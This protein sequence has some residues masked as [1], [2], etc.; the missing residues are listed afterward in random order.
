MRPIIKIIF[1]VV[2][3]LCAMQSVQAG[4]Q[5]EPQ[6]EVKGVSGAVLQNVT[7]RLTLEWRDVNI[8][9]AGSVAQFAQ[10]SQQA[11]KAA[12]A[13]YGYYQPQIQVTMKQGK[14]GPVIVYAIEPGMPVRIS[15]VL[16]RIEGEG[17]QNKKSCA[18]SH[19]FRYSAVMC[20]I[21]KRMWQRAT[22][23]LM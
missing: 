10:E 1:I 9:G 14:S 21:Q 13:P 7:A 22:S 8:E 12:L 23:C 17:S 4:S 18:R 20:L 19:A 16:I 5:V 6:F 2:L 3:S 15:N 11:V